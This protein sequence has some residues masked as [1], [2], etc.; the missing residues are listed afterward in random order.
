MDDQTSTT[1]NRNYVD[2]LDNDKTMYSPKPCIWDP[3]DIIHVLYRESLPF[4]EELKESKQRMTK[5]LTQK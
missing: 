5:Q 1:E 4:C 3:D 2:V